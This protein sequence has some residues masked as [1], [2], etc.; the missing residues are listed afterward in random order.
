MADGWCTDGR[1]LLCDVFT[2]PDSAAPFPDLPDGLRAG[3]LVVHGA[4]LRL[5]YLPLTV[6]EHRW[7]RS[8]TD[9]DTHYLKE[10]LRDQAGPG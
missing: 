6:P 5:L 9:A 2:P 3:V 4:S 10:C 8:P 7:T 1:E